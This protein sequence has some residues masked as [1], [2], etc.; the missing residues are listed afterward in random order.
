MKAVY[1]CISNKHTFLC[2]CSEHSSS[3]FD[4]LVTGVWAEAESFTS[5]QLFRMWFSGKTQREMG[6]LMMKTTMR[7]AEEVVLLFNTESK[8]ANTIRLSYTTPYKVQSPQ[9][10][11]SISPAREHTCSFLPSLEIK[12]LSPLPGEH[13]GRS[14]LESLL[15]CKVSQ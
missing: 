3:L 9:Q 11:T 12:L 14:R 10:S 5:S 1:I 15:A 2:R 8:S 6:W 13:I 7:L 4:W